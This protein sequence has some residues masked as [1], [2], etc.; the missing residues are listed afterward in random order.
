MMQGLAMMQQG[1]RQILVQ[2]MIPSNPPQLYN[3][4]QAVSELK[5]PTGEEAKYRRQSRSPVRRQSGNDT[6]H[7]VQRW[8]HVVGEPYKRCERVARKRFEARQAE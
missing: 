4:Y 7:L 2:N 3:D 8:D 1:L 5:E 6:Q